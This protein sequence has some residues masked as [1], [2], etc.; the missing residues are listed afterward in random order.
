M[1]ATLT[2]APGPG[3]ARAA[4][5]SDPTDRLSLLTFLYLLCVVIPVTMKLGSVYLSTLRILLL[6]VTLPMLVNLLTGRYGKTIPTDWLFL[7]H[8]MW[9][10][11]ALAINNPD[12]V[13]Q[14]APSVGVEFL[15]GYVLARATIRSRA[16]FVTMCRF[17]VLIVLT[18]FPFALLETQT[19][20]PLIIQAIRSIPGI[21]SVEITYI[22]KR[23][24]LERVQGVFAHPIHFGLFCS[25]AF[26]LAFVGL[27]DVTGTTRRFATSA[28]VGFSS[29]LA[30]S[31]GAIL[32][33]AL[34]LG[35]IVWAFAF[36]KVEG[37]WWLLVGLFALMWVAID[38]LSNRSPF[39]VF[40][41]Y[42][43]FSAHNAYWRSIIFEWGM[44]NIFG[45]V[46]NNVPA[47]PWFG[48]GLNDWIRP[49]F[50]FSG[51]MDN[52]WL[53]MGVR[54][55]FPGFLLI[56]AGFA[57]QVAKLIR[58]KLPPGH[59]ALFLRRASVFTF[60]GL[61]FTLAT[62]HVWGNVYSFVMFFVGATAWMVQPGAMDDDAP[63]PLSPQGRA[64]PSY[65]RFTPKARNATRP[66]ARTV[67]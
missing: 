22:G 50:M 32:A 25:V 54:Y 40:M 30:L 24:G 36:R 14:Q 52:F 12:K 59:P 51:S 26:S 48:I 9:L 49:S 45:S 8:A 66:Y 38:L 41:S 62:V 2:D 35:L 27:R 64:G 61:S 10:T 37:R 7:G 53:V 31:S 21:T 11:L 4:A 1:T 15:G 57:V 18:L 28:V 6:L 5:T 42:A 47:S 19:G 29:F 33:I 16:Q 46:E 65:S 3:R 20:T 39:D 17:L 13:I 55:G 58:L 63:R 60:L 67:R 23:L 43:T 44:M 34:Q 56:A